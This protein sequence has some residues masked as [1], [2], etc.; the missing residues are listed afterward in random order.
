MWCV[1]CN[2]SYWSVQINNIS[3]ATT[4]L[5]NKRSHFIEVRTSDGVDRTLFVVTRHFQQLQ[6]SSTEDYIKGTNDWKGLGGKWPWVT[7]RY[8]SEESRSSDRDFEM[9]G[10]P[11]KHPEQL[12]TEHNAGH[13]NDWGTSSR[14]LCVNAAPVLT[15]KITNIR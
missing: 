4:A 7:S 15:L 2:S 10:V 11:E 5:L 13:V 1:K 14:A 8:H 3:N 12:L 9:M 6:L